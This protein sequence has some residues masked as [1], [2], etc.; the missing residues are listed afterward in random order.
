[1]ATFGKCF[2]IVWTILFLTFFMETQAPPSCHHG[3]T[4]TPNGDAC[5]KLYLRPEKTWHSARRAC[6][7]EGGDLV[8]VCDESKSNFIRGLIAA[9]D[10]IWAWIG[11]HVILTENR[12]QWVDEDGTPTYTNWRYGYPDADLWDPMP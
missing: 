8:T 10:S 3:W 9:N 7:G 5:V 6:R 1:M 12:W 4:E 2:L 11:F